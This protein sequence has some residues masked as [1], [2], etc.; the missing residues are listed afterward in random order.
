MMDL[1]AGGCLAAASACSC[2][3]LGCRS[4]CCRVALCRLV[5]ACAQVSQKRQ[6]VGMQLD[7]QQ[8]RQ[9]FCTVTWLHTWSDHRLTHRTP[10][11][12]LTSHP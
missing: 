1:V 6:M 10:C 11:I 4:S 7:L 3:F 5:Q 8:Q 12:S 9:M 2:S